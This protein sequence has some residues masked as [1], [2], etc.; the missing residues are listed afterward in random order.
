MGRL[1]SITGLMRAM[2]DALAFANKTDDADFPVA[3][4]IDEI[5]GEGRRD[6]MFRLGATVKMGTMIFL[7]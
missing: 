3:A 5:T 7:G 2:A 4:H 1:S 6:L